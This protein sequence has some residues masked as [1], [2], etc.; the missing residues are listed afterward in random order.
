LIRRLPEFLLRPNLFKFDSSVDRNQPCSF[1]LG[2]GRVIRGWDEGVA[3]MQ[4]GG[5]RVPVIPPD[6]G[7]GACDLNHDGALSMEDSFLMPRYVVVP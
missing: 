4:V 3:G 7:Y 5:K 6:M 2:G 1:P